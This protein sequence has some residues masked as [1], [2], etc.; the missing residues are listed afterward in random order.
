MNE[1]RLTHPLDA[2]PAATEVGFLWS[3]FGELPRL[4]ASAELQSWALERG[5]LTRRLRERWAD[6]RVQ[7]LSEALTPP[8]PH[9]SLALGL[10]ADEAAWVRCVVLRGGERPRIYAR[11]VI[12]N[13][14]PNNPWA[15]VQALGEQPLGELLFTL[16]DLS[17]SDFEWALNAPWPESLAQASADQPE[18]LARRCTFVRQRA[19]LLLTEVFLQLQALTPCANS[20]D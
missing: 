12:P 18:V 20:S 17:R 19:P 10:A 3:A 4:T 8:L 13:W 1:P 6:T 2:P 5:S 16:P 15:E 14:H 7:V 9:E 11:T